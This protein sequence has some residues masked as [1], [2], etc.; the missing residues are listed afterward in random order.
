M[1]IKMNQEERK[2]KKR[3]NKQAGIK[4]AGPHERRGRKRG[5]EGGQSGG[6]GAILTGKLST[7][8]HD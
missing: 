2:K 1:N 5:R 3:I 4:F 6:V 7:I 8:E